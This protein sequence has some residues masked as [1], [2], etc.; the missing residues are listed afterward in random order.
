MRTFDDR[1][2]RGAF[3]TAALLAVL[4]VP[5]RAGGAPDLALR[6]TGGGAAVRGAHGT[7]ADLR[8]EL[9]NAGTAPAFAVIVKAQTTVG[10]VG[11]PVRLQPGPAA[12][13]TMQR[14]VTFALVR[15]MREICI[16]AVL[17]RRGDGDPPD[18]NPENNRICRAIAVDP[19][20]TSQEVQQ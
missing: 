15:G 2:P 3:L 7:T 5:C 17:Q 16:D 18:P 10:P 9:A 4:A 1:R 14:S 20:P 11:Q 6:W 12:G 19:Q 13:A 8:F